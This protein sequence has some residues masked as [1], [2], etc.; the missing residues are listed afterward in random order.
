MEDKES[1]IL[2]LLNNNEIENSDIQFHHKLLQNTLNSINE[3]ISITDLNDA[4]LYVNKAF[5]ETYGYS[6]E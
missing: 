6:E 4:I 3:C 5:I 1:N 2:N